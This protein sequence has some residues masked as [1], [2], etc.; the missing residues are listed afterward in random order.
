MAGT[1]YFARLRGC[2]GRRFVGP[3]RDQ[4]TA[5]DSA[6]RTGAASWTVLPVSR[7]TARQ[8]ESMGI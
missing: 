6:F 4:D 2:Y 5:H 1:L 3:F 8:R 7:A